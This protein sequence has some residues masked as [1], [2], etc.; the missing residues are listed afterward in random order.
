MFMDYIFA[1]ALGHACSTIIDA[2]SMKMEWIYSKM[3]NQSPL[4]A[5]THIYCKRVSYNGY[6]VNSIITI[7]G[8]SDPTLQSRF[9][10]FASLLRYINT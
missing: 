8:P 10:L 4:C 2:R 7:V 6:A 1:T 3:A 9:E 5:F